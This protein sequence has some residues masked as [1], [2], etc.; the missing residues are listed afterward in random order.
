MNSDPIT[1]A[2]DTVWVLTA[3]VL[4]FFMQAGFA[5]LEAGMVRAKNTVN[6]LMKNYLNTA[7]ATLAFWAVGFGLMFGANASGWFGTDHFMVN[8]ASGWDFTFLF[9]QMMFATTAATIVSGALA[10]RIRY[11]SY[12]LAALIIVAIIYPVFGSWAWGSN[13]GDTQGWLKQWGFIDFAGSTVVHSVGGWCALAGIIVLGPRLGRFSSQGEA[14]I[15]PGHNLP[16]IALGAFILWVGWFGFNGGSTLKALPSI[17][18]IILNTQ[19]A[20]AAG[21]MGA[22]LCLLL[23]GRPILVTYVFNGGLG[24][25]VAICAGADTFTPVGSLVTGLVS[26]LLVT[27]FVSLLDRLKWDDCVG[28][29]SVHGVCGAWGTIAVALFGPAAGIDQLMKQSLGVGAAFLWT[30]PAAIVMFKIIDLI[31]GLR[32]PSVDEQR[33]L[34]FSEHDEVSYP[35]FQQ[36]QL[37]RGKGEKAA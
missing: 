14:R 9:F 31:A 23:N 3:G 7:V 35:E 15:I 16:L 21:V 18:A 37:H 30:F 29:V 36:D 6:V 22:I 5:M 24:G 11:R 25:M 12:F 33:G 2:L 20:G 19:M 10:E 4:V 32:V 34:D 1:L 17:G 26:G 28:A 27:V 13:Y 8:H